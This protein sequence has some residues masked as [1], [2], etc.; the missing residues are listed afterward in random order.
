MNSDRFKSK[1]KVTKQKLRGGYYTPSLLAKFVCQQVINK[2]SVHILEPSF[3]DG[4]FL[5]ECTTTLSAR[6]HARDVRITGVELDNIEFKK[7]VQRIMES[8]NDRLS[9]SF[10]NADFFTIYPQLK[11]A[12]VNA[13]VGNPPFIRFQHFDETS[14]NTAFKHLFDSGFKP[15]KLANAWAAFVQLSITLLNEGGN[16]GM[17]IPA[18]LLQVKYAE[19]LRV[20]ILTHFDYTTIIG[21]DKIVFPDILQ[22]V[23]ILLCHGKRKENHNSLFPGM[24]RYVSV[25]NGA[26]LS[27]LTLDEHKFITPD[28]TLLSGHKWTSLF[29]DRWVVDKMLKCLKNE[30]VTLLGEHVSVNVGIVTGRNKFFVVNEQTTDDYELHEFTTP[31]V[32]KTSALESIDFDDAD[33]VKYKVQYPARLL[34]LKGIHENEFT[35]GLRRYI[36]EGESE[37]VHQGYKCRIRQRWYEVPSV[38]IPDGFLYRQ[39]Y[40]YPLL[41]NNSSNLVC[42]DTIHRV[43]L[44]NK[45]IDMDLLSA[46]FVNSFT[47]AWSELY[48]RSYG[49]GVLELEPREAEQLPIIYPD[50]NV[51]NVKHIKELVAENKI[52]EALDYVDE[53]LLH[54]YLNVPKSMTTNFRNVW[55]T[56]SERRNGRT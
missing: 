5:E 16:L 35:P 15:N 13:V 17:V 7:G 44:K 31:L 52:I 26:S 36:N 40:K 56:L 42:T 32:G 18:E 19:E 30:G 54:R 43:R 41:V 46:S 50:Q 9:L 39:I 27:R 45:S 23:V 10:H 4:N 48:G 47:F 25:E 20:Q 33:Y 29:V 12:G 28:P 11:A 51:L 34:D 21:F 24:I 55:L 8:S 53:L 38:Y 14:R 1:S 3:G 37:G 6:S 49:G 2:D 22:E